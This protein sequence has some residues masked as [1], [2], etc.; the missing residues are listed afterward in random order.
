[1][2][3]SERSCFGIQA[4][5]PSG[6]PLY[7]QARE[8]L[9]IAEEQDEPKH[10]DNDGGSQSLREEKCVKQ[11]NIDNHRSEKRKGEGEIAIHE[12][13]HAADYLNGADNEVIVGLMHR[14]GELPRQAR[15]HLGWYEMEETVQPED[16]EDKTQQKARYQNE[17]FH[18]CSL[19]LSTRCQATRLNF[20]FPAPRP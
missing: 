9:S 16:D 2:S 14:P 19:S 5:P 18:E 12:Q 11:Q 13:Q 10:G 15:G 3:N 6:G 8:V 20:L 1:M 17:N 4:A 7:E